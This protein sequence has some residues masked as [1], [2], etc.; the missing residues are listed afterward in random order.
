MGAQELEFIRFL[1]L[2]DETGAL[3]HVVLIGS[4][5]EYLY[6]RA[7]V[8]EEFES[9]IRTLDMDFLVRNLRRPSPAVQLAAE[10]RKHGYLVSSD[11]L[12]GVTKIYSGEG[13]E[14]EFLIGKRGAG[15]E[16]ALRTNL[17]VTAQSLRHMEILTNWM[18]SVDYEGMKVNV[19]APEAYA[20]HK[21]VVNHERGRKREKDALAI[22]HLWPYL[23]GGKLEQVLAKLTRGERARMD[24]FMNE[25]GLGI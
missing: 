4:W 11:T 3:D 24:A 9:N 22:V 16:T 17:G 19:P 7:G 12:T 13:L 25:K 20:V 6:E 10:A 2:L 5:A 21:M 23:D 1:R 15:V 18:L 14:I 8:L